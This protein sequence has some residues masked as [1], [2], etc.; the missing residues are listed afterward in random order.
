MRKRLI[1]TFLAALTAM[2]SVASAAPAT[3]PHAAPYAYGS[4][5]FTGLLADSYRQIHA[6]DPQTFYAWMDKDPQSVALGKAAAGKP[7]PGWDA[8]LKQ[9]KAALARA[10]TPA[11]KAQLEMQDAA[12]LHKTIKASLPHFSLDEGYEFTNAVRKG[13]RQCVLQATLMASLLQSMGVD[14]GLVMVYKNIAGQDSN[15]GHAVTL[16]KRA[17]GK[18]VLVDCSDPTP[19]VKHQGLFAAD[20]RTGQYRYVEPVY[21]GASATI[22]GYTPDGETQK[23]APRGISPLD[24]DFVRSQIEYYRGERTP[25]GLLAPHPTVAGLA[26]EAKHLRTSVAEC[27]QNPLAQYMLGRVYLKEAKLST[28]RRQ[29][30]VAYGL[31]ARQGRVPQGCRDAMTEAKMTQAKL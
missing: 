15:N 3:P 6:A 5:A 19:F 27:P 4:T 8:M 25:G 22:V 31:Y 23:I 10:A 29:L 1:P 30:T 24:Y 18:D 11:Q 13:E 9:K 20:A 26:A 7:M 14:A 17:D 28:A 2:A 21:A 12:W 16:M